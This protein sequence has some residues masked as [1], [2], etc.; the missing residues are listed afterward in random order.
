MK[1]NIAALACLLVFL[2]SVS[3]CTNQGTGSVIDSDDSNNI[4]VLD[5][6]GIISEEQC[7]ARGLN[8]KVI[9]LESQYCGHCK[10]TMPEFKEACSEKGIEPVILDVSDKDQR[11][12]MESYSL[13]IMYTPT[14]VFGCRYII[15]ARSKQDYLNLLAEF[16]GD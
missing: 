11:K 5:S 7:S 15:G 4:L 2:I 6:D 12:Q 1:K 16:L 13:D 10:A 8:N 14:F 3:G 9:M